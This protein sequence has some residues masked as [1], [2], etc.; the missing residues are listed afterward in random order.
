MEARVDAGLTK[1]IGISNF[2]ENQI[3]RIVANARIKPVNLQVEL[4]VQFQQTSLRECC[5]KH[6]IT[7]CAYAPLGSPGRAAFYV[8]MGRY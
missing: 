4:H 8:M 2:N 6:G 7:I 1:S 5:E 3:E